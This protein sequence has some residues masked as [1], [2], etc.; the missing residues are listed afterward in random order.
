MAR[1]GTV[2]TTVQAAVDAAVAGGTVQVSGDCTGVSTVGGTGANGQ[3]TKN[4]T[5]EGGYDSSDWA[6]APD[7]VAHPTTLDASGGGRVVYVDYPAIVT[8]RGLVI[9]G[10]YQID[11]WGEGNG[12]GIYN[13][14]T[15]TIDRC[16]VR[17][18]SAHSG[19]GIYNDRHLTV[20]RSLIAGNTADV[21]GGAGGGIF[22]RNQGWA[23]SLSIINSTLANNTADNSG[24]AIWSQ[25]PTGT[26]EF[27]TL[28]GNSAAWAA[29]GAG[30]LFLSGASLTVKGTILANNSPRNCVTKDSA[31]VVDGWYNLDD[32]SSCGFTS[33]GTLHTDPLLGPLA[34]NGGPT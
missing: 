12:G 21:S 29:E 3:L 5:I 2:Y 1:L 11:Q 9:Q 7:P 34:D 31:V 33:A 26:L 32:G 15:L 24:G 20:V 16:T 4:L 28:A 8:L 6:A 17:N 30:G 10:G 13:D 22:S 27:S 18:S 14:G 19:A 25:A 23:S